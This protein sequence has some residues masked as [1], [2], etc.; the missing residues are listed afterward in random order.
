MAHIPAD[1]VQE[2]WRE[3]N[4]KTW[5]EFFKVVHAHR[6]NAEGITENLIHMI[7][8]MKSQLEHTPFPNSPEKLQEVLNHQ[9][10]E[11]GKSAR[12]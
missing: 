12:P 10:T 2:L 8:D 11:M 6:G 5:P 9:L 7:E 3:T 1:D 4:P